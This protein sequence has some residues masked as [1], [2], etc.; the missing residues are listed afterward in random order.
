MPRN[1][2]PEGQGGT[3]EDIDDT[4]KR[5]T[6]ESVI[7]RQHVSDDSVADGLVSKAAENGGVLVVGAT[8]TRRLK[9][10]LFGGTPDRVVKK[11]RQRGVPVIVYAAPASLSG[12][13]ED[14]LFPV[15][16]I[17]KRVRERPNSDERDIQ[18]A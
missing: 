18:G 9:R 10:W 12:K 7:N 3:E 6:N 14:R 5:L 13:I 8:R 15:Y 1:V 2:D 11:A 4:V 16:R 17:Y